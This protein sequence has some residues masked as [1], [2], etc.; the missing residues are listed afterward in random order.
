LEREQLEQ[1]RAA[2]SDRER[3]PRSHRQLSDADTLKCAAHT[4]GAV[5]G[6]LAADSRLWVNGRQ[7]RGRRLD[8][9]KGPDATRDRARLRILYCVPEKRRLG[10]ERNRGHQDHRSSSS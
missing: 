1:Q 3:Y 4:E 9:V 8:E 6:A 10:A 5:P 2:H 7:L